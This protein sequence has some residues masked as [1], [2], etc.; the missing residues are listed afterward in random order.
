M[1]KKVFYPL[2]ALLL[3]AGMTSC[4]SQKK[5]VYFQGA[6]E[7]YAEAQLIAQRYDIKIKP[8]D[9]IMIRLNSSESKLLEIFTQEVT[10]GSQSTSISQG[11]NINNVYGYTVDNNGNVTL[12]SIGTV[13]VGGMTTA[14]CAKEI[15]Q[16]IAR[17]GL[18]G[19]PDITVKLL[20]ASATVVGAV[21]KPGVYELSSERN[22]IVDILAKAGDIE[23]A[24][25]K[26]NIRLFR[27]E[28]GTRTMYTLDIT[29]ADVFNNPAF[30]VQQNDMIYVQP[31]RSRSVRSSAFY[32]Y[33]SAFGGTIMG[34]A[35]MTL[36][37]VSL[38]RSKK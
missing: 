16:A 2:I 37:V 6:E 38:T 15:E 12:P 1:I 35:S 11:E 4:V 27:E 36:S 21:N 22:S 34:L 33:L 18:I 32:T 29:K 9:N 20:N 5:V 28:N 17:K 10:I 14:A 31:K 3:L 25:L 30:Y 13:H 23:D 19:K 26:N 8:A 24:G 7:A